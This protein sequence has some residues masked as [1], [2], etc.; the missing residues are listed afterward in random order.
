MG[1]EWW[2]VNSSPEYLSWQPDRESRQHGRRSQ[3]PFFSA[4]LANARHVELCVF[5]ARGLARNGGGV[6]MYVMGWHL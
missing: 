3:P 5:V 1:S 2:K 6:G 4:E